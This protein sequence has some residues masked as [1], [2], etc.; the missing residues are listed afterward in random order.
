MEKLTP[1]Y[2]QAH[3]KAEWFRVG[4]AVVIRPDLK[5]EMPYGKFVTEQMIELAGQPAFVT[6]R[7]DISYRLSGADH[8]IGFYSWQDYMLKPPEED[9]SMTEFEAILL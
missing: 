5:E 7:D 1:D 3:C 6:R 8:H 9:V 4:D 2:C